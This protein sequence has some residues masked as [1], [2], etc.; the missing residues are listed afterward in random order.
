MCNG[1]IS[2]FPI[3]VTT[4]KPNNS[5]NETAAAARGSEEHGVEEENGSAQRQCAF[6]LRSHLTSSPLR[7]LL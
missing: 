4:S 2:G 7:A 6:L 1:S 3:S 5:P